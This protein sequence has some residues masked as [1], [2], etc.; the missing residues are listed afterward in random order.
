MKTEQNYKYYLSTEGYYF[1]YRP[2]N[3]DATIERAILFDTKDNQLE[4]IR[5]DGR[6]HFKIINAFEA[7]VSTKLS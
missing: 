2:D 7:M 5:V 6:D 4:S 3:Y 1:M